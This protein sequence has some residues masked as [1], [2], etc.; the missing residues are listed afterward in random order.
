MTPTEEHLWIKLWQ[1]L[2][3]Q[4]NP[5]HPLYGRKTEKNTTAEIND[6]TTEEATNSTAVTTYPNWVTLEF[7]NPN[8]VPRLWWR[9]NQQANTSML[10]LQADEV[11]IVLSDR[12]P[13]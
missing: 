7:P 1:A 11:Y 3:Q 4:L 13:L 10:N 5:R 6:N 2:I 12:A 8:R 9:I